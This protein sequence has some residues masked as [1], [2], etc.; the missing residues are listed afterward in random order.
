MLR[1][2]LLRRELINFWD[3]SIAIIVTRSTGE[4]IFWE[5]PRRRHIHPSRVSNIK[6][7][8][9]E[10]IWFCERRGTMPKQ[11]IAVSHN[12]QFPS[13]DFVCQIFLDLA[14]KSTKIW[15]ALTYRNIRS[16]ITRTYHHMPMVVQV[17][18]W[19]PKGRGLMAFQQKR[20]KW[21]SIS[22]YLEWWWSQSSSP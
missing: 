19:H 5:F 11:T 14:S 20:L 17:N 22:D 3:F 12:L 18:P 13:A 1:K 9:T 6:P 4:E 2:S 21:A 16:Q 8:F 15:W 10:V 7:R